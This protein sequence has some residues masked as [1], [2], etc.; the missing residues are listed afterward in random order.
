M[1]AKR[2]IS[3]YLT[4]VMIVGLIAG[5]S[6]GNQSGGGGQNGESSGTDKGTNVQQS[7][8]VYAN[9]LSRT[10]EVT[11]KFGIFDGGNGTGYIEAG[12]KEFEK[13]YPNV[14]IELSASPDIATLIDTKIGSGDDGDMYDLFTNASNWQ[15]LV[16]AGKL[17]ILDDVWD[18]ELE[19]TPGVKI[20]EIANDSIFDY[21]YVGGWPDGKRH[22]HGFPVVSGGYYGIYFNKHLFAEKG[23][24]ENP[25]TW[26]EFLDL[27]EEI[28]ADGV[29]PLV[30][31]GIYSTYLWD[32]LVGAKIFEM[33]DASGGLEAYTQSYRNY[34]SDFYT[35]P[36]TVATWE[37]IAQLGRL[38]YFHEGIGAMNH[39]QSQMQVIQ[40]SAAM[41]STGSWVGSEMEDSVPEG[42]EWGYMTIPFRETTDTPLY[43]FGN[44][45]NSVYHVWAGKPDINKAW[46]KEFIRILCNMDLQVVCADNGGVPML[47]KDFGTKTEHT[48][49]MSQAVRATMEYI[50][51]NGVRFENST[52]GTE[53]APVGPTLAEATQYMYDNYIPIIF[54]EVKAEDVLN[55]CQGLL[56]RAW[57]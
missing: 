42:F 15:D 17:E 22:V 41:V 49:S 2:W 29:K 6:N 38:G 13:R 3:I 36:Y 51:L 27:C 39:T 23:W 4:V 1:K 8:A 33:A 7:D 30:F 57:E 9:G 55:E 34:G 24:N 54:G 19:D 25:Q 44:G 10:E 56:D 12:I 18:Y 32:G 46:C 31:P 53:S 26:Q 35:N 14:N 37:K 21:S 5:C 40:G 11:L 16:K 28:K 45:N 50:A 43:T 47:R 20:R 48:E 52:P